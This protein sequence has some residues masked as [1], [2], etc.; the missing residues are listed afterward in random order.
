[1]F[2]F[3]YHYCFNV[4]TIVSSN[5][6]QDFHGTSYNSRKRYEAE[7]YFWGVQILVPYVHPP[8]LVHN[9]RDK[10]NHRFLAP[11]ERQVRARGGDVP[12]TPGSAVFEPTSLSGSRP[13]SRTSSHV[14]TRPKYKIPINGNPGVV[15]FSHRSRDKSVSFAHPLGNVVIRVQYHLGR[16]A[17]LP[18]IDVE[19]IS[20]TS[21]TN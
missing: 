17:G 9:G 12:R 8:F 5:R 13:R 19:N 10:G 4:E 14:V 11:S 16:P 21:I 2:Y 6:A 7:L 15:L 20:N 1:M 3:R 18:I